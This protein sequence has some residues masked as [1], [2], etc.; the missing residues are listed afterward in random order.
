[1]KM[2]LLRLYHVK[3]VG[4]FIP[5]FLMILYLEGDS[6]GNQV[7]LEKPPEKVIYLSINPSVYNLSVMP[8]FLMIL[9]LE[10]DSGGNQ[11]IL[12]KPPEKVIYLSIHLSVYI[13]ISNACLPHDSIPGGGFWRQSG[14]PAETT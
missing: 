3:K 1:M 5:A 8:A 13:S 12:E 2:I 9:Y 11:V 6:G 14:P 7:I 10:G 4:V